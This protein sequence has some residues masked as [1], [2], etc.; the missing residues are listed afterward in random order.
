M[1]SFD[2]MRDPDVKVT[3]SELKE[4][5]RLERKR[6]SLESRISGLSGQTL[7][8]ARIELAEIKAKLERLSNYRG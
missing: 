8:A 5:E 3:R 4:R 2:P 1:A 6:V 7:E